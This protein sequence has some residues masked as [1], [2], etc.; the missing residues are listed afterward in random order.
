MTTE[1]IDIIVSERGSR[2]VKRNI[3]GIGGAGQTAARGVQFLRSAL[4][5]LGSALL[6]RELTQMADTYT[7]I[8]NRLKLVT[9][10]T[11]NLAAINDRLFESAQRTRTSY[12]ATSDLYAR[13]ARN[14]GELGLSQERLLGI[15]ET[16]NQ[17]IRV[18]GGSAQ[19][20]AAGVRQF[21]QAI[22]SGALRGDELISVLENMPRLAQA[23]ATGM[24]VSIGELRELGA[25]GAL[26]ADRIIAALET[27]APEIAREFEQMTPTIG[28]AFTVL[29][30]S[31]LRFIGELDQALGISETFARL[32]IFLAEHLDTVAKLA[33]VAGI[34]LAAAFS[35]S[36]IGRIGTTIGQVIALERALGAAS[37]SSALFSAAMKLGQRAVI[38]LTAAI[39]A[40]P[41]GFLIVALTTV[42]SLL[43]VFRD[44]IK[45]TADGVVS[46]GDV[47]RAVFSFIMDLIRPVVEFFKDAWDGSIETV[48]GKLGD[49]LNSVLSILGSVVSFVKS[50]I[51]AQIALWVGGFKT[52]VGVWNLLPDA[53]RALGAAA[54]NALIDI[55]DTGISGIVRGVGNL[56]EFI[57]SAFSAVGLENPFAGLFDDFET[58]LDR[59]R[60]EG[61]PA[62]GAVF[63]EIGGIASREFSEAFGTD[64]IGTAID[65]IMARAREIAEARAANTGPLNPGG[66][67]PG[68]PELPGGPGA[69]GAG[70]GASAAELNDQLKL[71][72]DLLEEI[73]GPAQDYADK[74]EALD[75]LLQMGAITAEQYADKW[76]EIRLEFLETQTTFA[77]GLERGLLRVQEDLNDMA[78]DIERV[79]TN[80]F[81]AAEDALTEFISTGK[82]D[83][84][85]F[86]NS[87]LEDLIRLSVRQ[88]VL[89]PLANA[90]GG[91]LGFDASG[92]FGGGGDNG[93]A[94]LNQSAT[95]LTGS[96]AALTQAAGA[97]AAGGGLG[98][99]IG[100]QLNQ[101]TQAAT[102][103]TQA[104]ST[105][106]GSVT[107]LPG[108]FGAFQGGLSSIFSGLQGGLGG[109]FSGLTQN[110][111]GLFSNLMSGLG[112]IFSSIF[113]GGGGGGG[114]LSS[115]IGGI[116]GGG[117]IGFATG[118][119]FTVGGGGGV[120]SQLVQFRASPGER[121]EVKRPGDQSETG[122]Q[123]QQIVFNIQTP[124]TEGFKR[125]ESQI[126]ARL[127]RM[128]QKGRRNL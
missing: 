45:V 17:A 100:G 42:I 97:L 26:T 61:A 6:L 92:A 126:A 10:G 70:A 39:A 67:I 37:V 38:G 79:F 71:M 73:I 21:G 57:G 125:S 30:N 88:T 40:N 89:K 48:T 32:I 46:L 122:G 120:D 102:Q 15:T 33:A 78:S 50:I 24:G 123:R 16:V 41:I 93:S 29:N 127:A 43:T 66:T 4:V 28:E 68:D 95:A 84:K 105:A 116:F 20:A 103:A 109:L 7:L 83:F 55:V 101:A 52:I 59:F 34:A 63:G 118:G 3:E 119:G 27:T 107:Q 23:I 54:V 22:G 9:T 69:G 53:F 11:E 124:D 106:A 91:L 80:A 64:F 128:T 35:V 65:T 112:N 14:A 87:I 110:L 5:G 8:T 86:V 13:I 58:G 96:A 36:L 1:R 75:T 104:A 114:F 117:G 99:G 85:G 98:G 113:S 25:E 31:V 81:G 62:V 108:I 49:F 2:V 90:L 94:A 82:L 51:N 19:E 12:E 76:R 72:L 111:G 74:V 44:D 47:F 56:L 77:A 121:V 115:I 60:I 18:S